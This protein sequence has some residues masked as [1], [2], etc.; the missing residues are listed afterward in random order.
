MQIIEINEE[1]TH[2]KD[3]HEDNLAVGIDFGT[4][5]SLIAISQKHS[6][7]IIKDDSGNELIPSIITSINGD[8]IIGDPSKIENTIYSIKRLFGKNK[9]EVLNNPALLSIV[10]DVIDI[11]HEK[12]RLKFGNQ[13]ITIPEA[14]A[15]IFK[16]LKKQ[17][18]RELNSS[19]NKAVI[20]VP[21]YFNDA[22]RGEVMLAAKIAGFEVL[23]L[24]AEPSAAGYAFGLNKKNTGSYMV[25]DLGRGTFDI[26]IIDM[27]EGI[28][29]V[30]A[31]S[32][33]NMLGDDDID[34]LIADYL[35][36]EYQLTKSKGLIAF[37]KKVKEELTYNESRSNMFH[38]GKILSLERETLE[39][40]ISTLI[41]RSIN[42]AKNT[43]KESG[44]PNIN[45]IILV[46]GSTRIPLISKMLKNN[47]DTII[48]AENFSKLDMDS[49]NYI[50]PDKVVV[51]GAALQAENLTCR[52]NNNPLL[53]DVLPLS[54]GIE[55][56]GGIIE[57]IILKN[58]PI[59]I[60]IT[61]SYTTYVDN[62]TSIEIHILQGEREMVKDC[63]SLTRFSLNNLP[64]MKAGSIRIEITFSIDAD[65]ILSVSA[66][67]KTSQRSHIIEIKPSYGLDEDEIN[68]ILENAY[69][70]AAIDHENKLLQETIIDTKSLI[71]HLENA[72][73]EMAH[74]LSEDEMN[75]IKQK[76]ELVR[77]TVE[78]NNRD[79]IIKQKNSL[80]NITEN[81]ASLRM[82]NMISATLKGK[83][84]D[85]I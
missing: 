58:S 66:L 2:T 83:H 27:Q 60:S 35:A 41:E 1:G 19:I 17:A 11:D 85:E 84:I 43:L 33:D 37:A 31:T 79:L 78:L 25:Y 73:K 57:K 14:G 30:A 45:S 49:S 38:D 29:R 61:S 71:Y 75:E 4:T 23:R 3:Q 20:T 34:R 77:K 70:N 80:E 46:G 26:S 10:Q 82:N 12:L 63:R 7:K 74:L 5:H 32:G 68:I 40:L 24:I 62:Q 56:Y 22:A 13:S 6:I 42:I 52:N 51:S 48:L 9:E 18:E 72:I 21:A 69:K 76:I 39:R 8:F 55:L 16:Y 36:N 47:F 15:E 50:D 81:F 54:L 44:L 65:G 28:L 64:P 67:E 59:P 53:I